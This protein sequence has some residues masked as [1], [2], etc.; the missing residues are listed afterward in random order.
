MRLKRRDRQE[1]ERSARSLKMSLAAFLR[2]AA[3]EKASRATRRAACLAYPD[4]IA[5]SPEAERNPK[6]FIRSKLR[7]RHAIDSSLIRVSSSRFGPRPPR[8]K[9]W[10]R[11]LWEIA[12]LPILTSAANLQEAGWLLENHEIILRLVKDGDVRPALDFDAEAKALHALAEAYA[13]RMDAADAAIVRL[14]ELYPTH[15]VLTVDKQNFR[16]Y[17]RNRTQTISCLLPPD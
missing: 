11:D 14:S 16:I 10:A 4:Q 3:R 5:L 9:V 2:E 1:F 13:P 12:T 17:R 6:E 8:R 7:A 15:K